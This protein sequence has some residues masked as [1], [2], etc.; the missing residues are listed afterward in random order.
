MKKMFSIKDIQRHAQKL[1]KFK[2]SPKFGLV[3]RFS[4]VK[5]SNQGIVTKN[6]FKMP[7]TL[8]FN[9]GK[10]RAKI[11]G[12][13]LILKN[14]VN[15]NKI[16]MRNFCIKNTFEIDEKQ[17]N[18][19]LN[20]KTDANFDVN[21]NAKIDTNSDAKFEENLKKYLDRNFKNK[22][23]QQEDLKQLLNTLME[24]PKKFKKNR[25]VFDV[26]EEAPPFIQILTCI[27]VAPFIFLALMIIIGIWWIVVYGIYSDIC[28]ICFGKYVDR[29]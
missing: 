17:Q 28:W 2:T 15:F 20:K 29:S 27:F 4:G 21:F 19:I 13:A 10:N 25:D 26:F 3:R 9:Q 24:N 14:S 12:N 5:A 23:N 6:S 22:V 11:V 16:F 8:V 7:K 1:V 18:D